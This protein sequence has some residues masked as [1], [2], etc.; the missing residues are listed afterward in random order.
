MKRNKRKYKA[1]K[2]TE[3]KIN[4]ERKKRKETRKRMQKETSEINKT[5]KEK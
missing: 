5:E 4:Q 3:D 1:G 2:K